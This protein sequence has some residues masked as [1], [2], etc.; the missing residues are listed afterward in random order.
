M[1]IAATVNDELTRHH[2]SYD[3]LPHPHTGSSLETAEEAHVPGDRIAKGV[4]LEDMEGYVLAVVPASQHVHLGRL[5][6]YSHRQL[7]LSTEH[8][9]GEVFSDCE[10]GAIPPLGPAYGL[11]TVVDEGLLTGTTDVF[12]EAGDHEHLVRVRADDFRR[13]LKEATVEPLTSP[14]G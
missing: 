9:V 10:P 8:A 4:L 2:V 5:H 14:K 1:T 13:L 7:G 12:F 3:L 6:R 11:E